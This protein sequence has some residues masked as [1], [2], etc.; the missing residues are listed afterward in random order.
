MDEV[1]KDEATEEELALLVV[2]VKSV[3]KIDGVPV[4]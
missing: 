1:D 4:P 2:F 3:E